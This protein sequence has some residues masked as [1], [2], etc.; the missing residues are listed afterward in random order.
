VVDRWQVIVNPASGRPDGGAGWRALHSALRDAG[1]AFE[2]V[3]TDRPHHGEAL[4][5]RAV[6]DGRRRFLAVGG[7]G[8]VNDVV[9]GLMDSG[10]AD[11]RELTL[12]VAPL[13]TGNDWART[14][15]VPR[16]PQAIARM[17]AA[18]RTVLHDVGR[19]EFEAADSPGRWFVNVAGA[20][21][22][23][24]VLAGL[25]RPLPSAWAYLRGALAGLVSYRSPRFTIDAEGE[26]IA[27]R[28][29]LALV[30]NAR[31]CGHRMHVA[32]A[33]R[34][35]DGLLDLVAVEDLSLLRV[36]PKL[37]RLYD[38]RFLGDPAVRHR[39][40]QR[41]RIDADPPAELQAD[42]QL[43]GRTPATFSLRPRALRVVVP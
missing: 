19:I 33:A 27:G 43:L 14:L 20:G 13:G 7:D 36:L 23:A 41:V 24:H 16:E 31:Y 28:M 38:G 1:L 37:P 8:S 21:F 11:T 2:A 4:A 15:G 25:P 30:A 35:D 26:R 5:R 39:R 22:D 34:I 6:R 40:V 10:L 42:G 9:H 32:P 3:A 12:A 17:L 29:L 18:G